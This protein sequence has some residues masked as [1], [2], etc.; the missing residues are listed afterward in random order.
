MDKKSKFVY[1]GPVWLFD[2]ILDYNWI[3][4]TW[5]PTEAKAL[6]NLS[7]QYKSSHNFVPGTKIEL[8]EDY[9]KEVSTL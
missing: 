3:G 6:S 5:A 2:T 9:I 4:E 7:Y 1:E 8:S